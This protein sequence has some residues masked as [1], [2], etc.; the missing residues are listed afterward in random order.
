MTIEVRK[1]SSLAGC[2]TWWRIF[3]GSILSIEASGII[4]EWGLALPEGLWDEFH[5]V[6]IHTV[7]CSVCWLRPHVAATLELKR[8]A[9]RWLMTG[10]SSCWWHT[11]CKPDCVFGYYH[12]LWFQS[13]SINSENHPSPEALKTL[14]R[15]K[16]SN[17]QKLLQ[18]RK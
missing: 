2:R 10:C 5:S 8:A 4:C 6:A 16:K 18:T 15:E 11:F 12:I 14:K 13:L 9:C 17:F 7:S 1:K 3:D